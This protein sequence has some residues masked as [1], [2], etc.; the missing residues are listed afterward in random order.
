[1]PR[2]R[3]APGELA[4]AI[5]PHLPPAATI[6]NGD[7]KARV[8]RAA[9]GSENSRRTPYAWDAVIRPHRSRRWVLVAMLLVANTT[10]CGSSDDAP[11]GSV[12]LDERRGAIHGVGLGASKAEVRARFGDYGTKPEPY[13]IEPLEVDEEEG[14]G[15]P[16]S[17][18]TGPHHVGPGGL[19]GEQVTLR[20]RGA[21]FFV[22]NDR[23]FGFM[24]TD[25]DAQTL[26]GMSVGDDLAEVKEAYP[27]L[28]CEPESQGDTTAPQ[29]AHCAGRAKQGRFVYFGG[30]PVES[31]TVME[32]S[33]GSYARY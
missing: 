21:S 13:P 29:K 6:P 26:R 16:W 14:S 22:R 20:Y 8:D 1:M 33:F 11:I 28:G 24:V 3:H 4:V 2:L 23:V 27:E 15:G 5:F 19:G 31:I 17:V 25:P 7:L 9:R 30:D 32:R 12:T 10:G 18:A